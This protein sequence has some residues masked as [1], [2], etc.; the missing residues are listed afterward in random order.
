MWMD[1]N[2]LTTSVADSATQP[3]KLS[4]CIYI[5][6]VAADFIEETFVVISPSFLD[7]YNLTPAS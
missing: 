6:S 2:L 5:S 4:I 7:L 1:I 3:T